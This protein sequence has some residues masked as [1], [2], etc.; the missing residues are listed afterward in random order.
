MVQNGFRSL[1]CH[2]LEL[3]ESSRFITKFSTNERLFRYKRLNYG[4]NAA[5]EI[6]QHTLQQLHG[7][8][9]VRNIGDDIIVYGKTEQEHDENLDKCLQRLYDRGLRLNQSKCKFDSNTLEFFGQ[10]FSEAGTQPDQNV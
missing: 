10:I 7:L 1:I 9:G 8:R 2:Q 5:A 4:T 6:F 3:S